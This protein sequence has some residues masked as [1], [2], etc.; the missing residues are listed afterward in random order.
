M[1]TKQEAKKTLGKCASCKSWFSRIRELALFVDYQ[2]IKVEV[3]PTCAEDYYPEA[4][5]L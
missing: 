1:Q 2:D 4:V 3:C 5:I